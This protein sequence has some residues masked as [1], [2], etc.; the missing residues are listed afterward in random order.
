MCFDPRSRTL[1]RSFFSHFLFT[2]RAQA[3]ATLRT[4]DSIGENRDELDVRRAERERLLELRNRLQ[5]A[6]KRFID[7]RKSVVVES[8]K[9]LNEI[10]V[11]VLAVSI[12]VALLGAPTGFQKGYCFG[13][14]KQAGMLNLLKRSV[15]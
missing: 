3:F 12:I 6:S 11:L 10:A 5:G 15:T 9:K 13:Q 14:Y 8:V 4:S 7:V 1:P 2:L